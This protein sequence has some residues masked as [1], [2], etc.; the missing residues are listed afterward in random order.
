MAGAKKVERESGGEYRGSKMKRGG[1]TRRR[2]MGG[3]G[4]P[5]KVGL[6]GEKRVE[7]ERLVDGVRGGEIEGCGV[8]VKMD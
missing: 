3:G 4:L 2:E 8:E 5:K 7:W 6:G 1:V